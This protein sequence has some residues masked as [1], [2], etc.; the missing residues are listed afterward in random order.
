MDG[1]IKAVPFL[2]TEQLPST[3]LSNIIKS[4][5]TVTPCQWAV[6]QRCRVK[7]ALS[8]EASDT[9][10]RP[11]KC[12]EVPSYMSP[13][14]R[15]SKHAR[16]SKSRATAI[17][18]EKRQTL[19]L[20]QSLQAL[21]PANPSETLGLQTIKSNVELNM[22]NAG[23]LGFQDHMR[24]HEQRARGQE[25]WSASQGAWFCCAVILAH[26]CSWDINSEESVQPGVTSARWSSTSDPRS[27]A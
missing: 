15:H 1:G 19:H 17:W 11:A 7:G 12:T 13:L 5:T 27:H 25:R 26:T 4:F 14:Q 23:T 10:F 3:P 18:L 8:Q 22:D 6:H 21:H 20:K 9:K 2:N 24:D 16:Q